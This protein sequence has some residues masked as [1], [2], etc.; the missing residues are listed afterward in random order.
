M[1]RVGAEEAERT[2]FGA[3]L[4]ALRETGLT[5]VYNSGV[6]SWETRRRA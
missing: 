1:H 2:L 3:V 6:W 4:D 5:F